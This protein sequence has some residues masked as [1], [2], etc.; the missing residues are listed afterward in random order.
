MQNHIDFIRFIKFYY[1]GLKKQCKKTSYFTYDEM[2]KEFMHHQK[3]ICRLFPG[4]CSEWDTILDSWRND[5]QEHSGATL[6][7]PDCL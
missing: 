4:H 5:M 6:D 3:R 2:T 1:Q 7:I